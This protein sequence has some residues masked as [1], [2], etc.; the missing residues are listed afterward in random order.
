VDHRRRYRGVR[1]GWFRRDCFH[2]AHAHPD[3]VPGGTD[4][5]TDDIHVR[6]TWGAQRVCLRVRLPE[7]VLLG[8]RVIVPGHISVGQRVCVRLG[9]CLPVAVRVPEPVP[10]RLSV[11]VP[12]RID[13]RVSVRIGV[14]GIAISISIGKHIYI[15]TPVFGTARV[16][17]GEHTIVPS[18]IRF[19]VAAV[20]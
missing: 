10:V 18:G 7:R 11:A 15:S 4:F 3:P 17:A 20:D 6:R 16:H 12:V 9:A 14:V 2:R 13:I 5:R 1:R 19:Y 8:E